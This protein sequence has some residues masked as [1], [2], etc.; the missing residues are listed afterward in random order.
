MM[1]R[2]GIFAAAAL[3][4]AATTANAAG[5][6][7][8][9]AS[10]GHVYQNTANSPCVFYGPGNCPQ[11]P[12]GWPDPTGNTGGGTPFVPNPLVQ[13]YTGTEYSVSWTNIIGGSFIL[14]IDINDTGTAQTLSNFTITFINGIN[15]A[16]PDYAFVGTIDLPNVF[17]GLGWADYILSPG[18]AGPTLGAGADT[19]CLLGLYQPFQVAAGTTALRFTFGFT[20]ANDGPDKV[21]AI[22]FLTPD[23]QCLP[24]TCSPTIPEP[25]SMVLLGTG[26]AALS[27]AVR[28]RRRNS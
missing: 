11:D 25:G 15:D 6:S 7:V 20:G 26:L 13:E 23:Q 2:T 17:N 27:F 28:R 22:P 16:T 9:H 14:G 19:Q 18:C 5:I 1:L 3:F 24:P 12:A 21:F 4:G 10:L 8:F